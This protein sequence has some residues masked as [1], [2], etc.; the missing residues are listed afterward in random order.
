MLLLAAVGYVGCDGGGGGSSSPPVGPSIGGQ[1]AG[2]FY[3]ARSS[4]PNER[5]ITATIRQDGD[6]VMIATS[7]VGIGARLTGTIDAAGSMVLIDGFDGEIWTTFFGPATAA[8]VTVA[9]FLRPPSDTD[10]TP[11][12]NVIQLI[13]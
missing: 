4:N 12:L 8:S 9:D 10:P 5:A 13:R 7:L 1:W 3:V 6:A 2:R 11:P